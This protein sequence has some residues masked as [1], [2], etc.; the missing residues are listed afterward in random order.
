MANYAQTVNVIGAIKTTK[1]AAA[2]DTTGLALKLYRARFGTLPVRL[3]GAAEP[4]DVMGAWTED[5]TALTISVVNPT[6]ETQTLALSVKGIP[7][8][9]TARL[10]RIAG[11]DEMAY[12]EPGKPPAVNIEE[13][14][15][16]PFS[17]KVTLPPL[18]ASI[19][20]LSAGTK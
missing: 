14:D 8:P 3:S 15:G 12:N 19:F 11:T 10:Y 4:L 7:F 1:T 20:I 9:R 16:V 2:F 18:S 13:I 5:K 17:S 6:K